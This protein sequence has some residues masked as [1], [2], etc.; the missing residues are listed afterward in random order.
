MKYFKFLLILFCT[1]T[2][3][4]S[5]SQSIRN[6]ENIHVYIQYLQSASVIFPD[7]LINEELFTANDV[8]NTDSE[9]LLQIEYKNLEVV[10]EDLADTLQKIDE[11]IYFQD[12]TYTP[13][14]MYQRGY[15]DGRLYYKNSGTFWGAYGIGF[16]APFTYLIP[17]LVAGGAM[18]A[19][20]PKER[21]LR[22]HDRRMLYNYSSQVIKESNELFNDINY[23][24]G[25]RKGAHNKKLGNVAGGFGAG[26][27]TSLIVVAV[28]YIALLGAIQ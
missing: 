14:F 4:Y 28:I 9:Y 1:L 6:N 16:V 2:F 5:F 23:S 20:A 13:A 17:S 25:Y 18:A 24:R 11:I 3:K 8:D 7:S 10:F 19:M 22:Y 15:Q 21:N 12:S 26:I 27:G